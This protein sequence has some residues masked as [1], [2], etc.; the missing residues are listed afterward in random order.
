M[1]GDLEGGVLLMLPSDRLTDMHDLLHRRPQGSCTSIEDVDLSGIAE[2]ANILAASFVNAMAD[3]AS[4]GVGM[5]APEI[6]LDMCQ[7]ALDAVL[8]RFNQ[9]GDHSMLTQAEVVS[10]QTGEV[11]CNLLLFL[12]P[13][14]LDRLVG[15]GEVVQ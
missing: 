2:F 3:G 15:A 4:L 6:S 5:Q 8:A 13:S 12:E 7:P 10:H 14:S 11:V 1:T 9:P